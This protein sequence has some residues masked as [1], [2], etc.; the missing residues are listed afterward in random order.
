VNF[1]AHLWLT[2]RAGLPLAGA[3]LGDVLRGP[4]PPA[5]PAPLARSVMLHR[6]VDAHTDRHPRVVAARSGF[7]QGARRYS[8]ILLDLLF[9]HVLAGDWAAH[10]SLS[11]AG[12]PL[13][14]F[15]DRAGREVADGGR[16]FEHAGDAVPDPARFSALLQSYATVAGM[17]R[18]IERTAGRLRRPQG[19]LGAAAGWQARIG[20]LRA[21]LPPLL[22]DLGRLG[23]MNHR[24][25]GPESTKV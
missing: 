5:M 12:V 23:D 16:W 24:P 25:C 6:Q 18:A 7:P 3:I 4:L 2:D 14:Q 21:D 11:H 22:A 10:T 9:D 17:E 1:L 19:L 13:A 8:G 15:A 20:A